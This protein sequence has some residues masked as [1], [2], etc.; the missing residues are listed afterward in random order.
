MLRREAFRAALVVLGL[1]CL[2]GL[3][4]LSFA[5]DPGIQ[6]SMIFGNLNGT[7][8]LAGLNMQIIVPVYLR[9]DDSVTFVHLPMA[10]DNNYV[11]HRDSGTILTPLSLWD[12]K[13]FLVPDPNSPRVG[14][15]SQS[16]LGFAYLADP[17]DPQNFLHTHG[18]WW[19]IAD[20]KLT[21]TNNIAVLGDTTFFSMGRNPAND[22]LALGLSDGATE[23]HP[24]IKWG[25]IYFP[26]NSP[27]AFVSPSP[28][29]YQVN[30]QFGANFIVT[31]TDPDTDAMV[32]TV[33]FGPTNYTFNAIQDVPGT[34][35]YRF[36]WVPE[37]GSAGTYP[38][39]FVVNDGNG[40]VIPLQLTLI[41]T[42]TGLSIS[43]MNAMPGGTISIPVSLDNQGSSSAVG[44]FSILINWNPEALTLNGITRAGRTGS[45]EYF[46]ITR[47]DG[48]PGSVRIV[49]LADIR[50]G[51]VSPPMHPGNGPI[52]MLE[53]S[54]VPDEALIGVELPV[55]FLNLE[56]ADNTLSDSTGYLL[57]HPE[58]TDGIISVVGP[59]QFMTGDI[60]LNGIPYE[61]A[62][63]VLFVNHL[64]SPL[65]FPFDAVQR[66]ASDV[67]AD[68][69]TET[70]ADLVYLI[71]IVN[72]VIP[73]PRLEPGT[74]N[75]TLLLASNDGK[76]KLYC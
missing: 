44:G 6:D 72:H 70:V 39:T 12:D 41:V 58:L 63:V 19:H 40:G 13:S 8:I 11:A 71:N 59:E 15:T 26:P 50:N 42:P 25:S 35:S 68:G 29:T 34:I 48:G 17:Y 20:F 47:D 2:I 75:M 56:P 24:A 5:Q 9:T 66:A 3:P 33:D 21:T 46:H 57:V 49:G 22:T 43:N 38:L 31:A 54:V 61:V 76:H 60:N 10:T 32:L 37:P 30:E 36:N 52:F 74:P 73:R 45:F 69:M 62:D 55:T 53:M 23:V 28:G 14:L 18:Q 7:P 65:L 64:T 27:P 1:V 16:I 51:N 4:T 67:N